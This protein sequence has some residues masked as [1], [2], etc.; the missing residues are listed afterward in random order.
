[1]QEAIEHLAYPSEGVRALANAAARVGS[2]VL[3]RSGHP[4]LPIADGVSELVVRPLSP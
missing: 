3:T 2:L 1:M 4:D